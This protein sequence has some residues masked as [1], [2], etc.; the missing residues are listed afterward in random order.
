MLLIYIDMIIYDIES[1]WEILRPD[2]RREIYGEIWE[3]VK[4]WENF[5]T[6]S[7]EGDIW[8]R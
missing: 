7:E 1:R 3:Y 6:E 5:K 4:M 2:Q 8:G